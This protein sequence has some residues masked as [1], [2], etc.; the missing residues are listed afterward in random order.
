MDYIL[1]LTGSG[2]RAVRDAVSSRIWPG[3]TEADSA[4]H[5]DSAPKVDTVSPLQRAGLI[6]TSLY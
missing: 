1:S 6:F 4:D 5:S 3:P 2:V